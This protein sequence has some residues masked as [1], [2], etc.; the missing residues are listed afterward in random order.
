MVMIVMLM[1]K[2]MVMTCCRLNRIP[3][4]WPPDPTLYTL[5]MHIHVYTHRH[6]FLKYVQSTNFPFS[7]ERIRL[8]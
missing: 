4:H 8:R 1:M 2:V 7:P 3:C 6:H 5:H